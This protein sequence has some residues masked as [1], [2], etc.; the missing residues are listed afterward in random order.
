[1]TR[2]EVILGLALLFVS[3]VAIGLWVRMLDWQKAWQVACGRA[4][5]WRHRAQRFG[6]LDAEREEFLKKDFG[7]KIGRSIKRDA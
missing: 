1:V 7:G 2:L 3:V 6:D 5:M 4:E